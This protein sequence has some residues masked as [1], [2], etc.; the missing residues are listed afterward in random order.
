MASGGSEIDMVIHQTAFTSSTS[1]NHDSHAHVNG[2]LVKVSNPLNRLA[3][4]DPLPGG[5][6]TI[7]YVPDT[8]KLYN[9][10]CI[11]ATDAGY[12]NLI[13]TF[14][15]I[16]NVVSDGRICHTEPLN[17]SNVNFGVLKNG[18]FV[19]GYISPEDVNTGIFKHLVAGLG[20]IV[21][22]GTNYVD[23]GWEEAYTAAGSSGDEY[24]E[25]T[26]GRTTIGW[27]KD[28]GL[29]LLQY[30]GHTGTP[31]WG[32]TMNELADKMIGFGAVEA[33]NLDG[34]GSTQMWKHGVQLGYSSDRS[35]YGVLDGT[36]EIGCPIGQ[37][38]GNL[39]AFEC[40][41]KVSTIICIH[42]DNTGFRSFLDTVSTRASSPASALSI[43]TLIVG[44]GIGVVVGIVAQKMWSTKQEYPDSELS[45]D[46]ALETQGLSTK[47][48]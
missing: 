30:D 23:E 39:S 28:G 3:V 38:K 43:G 21:R 46:D 16:G 27:D 25:M 2:H 32:A 18:S 31:S 40:A 1:A 4:V 36:Y 42:E 34:G 19:I 17:E 41:R 11:L 13:D 29:I 45:E 15:C 24:K 35:T 9:P 22:N 26:S 33:I 12:Y 44:L 37:G 5:C 8:A 10:S 47:L 20:W 48:S 6:G 14:E 7:A